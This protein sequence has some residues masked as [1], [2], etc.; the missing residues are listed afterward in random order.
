MRNSSE[1]K[2]FHFHVYYDFNEEFDKAF[3]LWSLA[4]DTLLARE[5]NRIMFLGQMNMNPN[6]P[7]TKAY[8]VIVTSP[9]YFGEVF[10]LL[11]LNRNGLSILVH[12]LT[13]DELEA[14]TSMAVWMGKEVPLDLDKL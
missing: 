13:N 4:N 3:D 12:P 7:H 11:L 8:F 5:R 9:F 10:K 14:H 6:G 1:I 2:G